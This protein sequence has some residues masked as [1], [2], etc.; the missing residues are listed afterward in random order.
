MVKAINEA[1]LSQ[2]PMRGGQL[3]IELACAEDGRHQRE[4]FLPHQTLFVHADQAP[5]AFSEMQLA[6]KVPGHPMLADLIV[7]VVQV[8]PYGQQPGFVIQI[9]QGLDQVTQA[10]DR[11][12]DPADPDEKTT[13]HHAD[14]T[15]TDAAEPAADDSDA[16]TGEDNDLPAWKKRTQDDSKPRL[17]RHDRLK[18]MSPNERSRLAKRANKPERAI[19]I[20]DHEPKVL[21][22]LLKNP[23]LTRG[24]VHDIARQRTINYQIVR[25]ICANPTWIQSEGLRYTL[26]INPKTPVG[27]ALKLLHTL[28]MKNLRAIAKNHG[29]REQIKRSA[30]RMVQERTA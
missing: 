14:A 30:L 1:Q 23:H 15:T 18:A 2:M 6:I 5:P 27:E 7:R 29:I 22:F 17:N 24:E 11:W 8:V 25:Q 16:A 26:T 13:A 10:M 28:N 21:L 12:L 19:L 3:T 20:R 9:L 4:S